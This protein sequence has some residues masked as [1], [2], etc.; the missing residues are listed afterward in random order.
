MAPGAA[1]REDR[2]D[3]LAEPV[4]LLQVR[5]TGQD[6]LGDAEAGV[7]LDP[8]RDLGVAADERGARA[9]ADQ[10]DAGP[11]VGGY[12]EVATVAALVQFAHA[13]LPFRLAA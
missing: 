4:R 2:Q 3:A 6:E 12:G 5:V 9:A 7:L 13:P 8:V 10:A 1:P 11:Q